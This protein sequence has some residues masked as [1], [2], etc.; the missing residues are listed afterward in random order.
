MASVEII[1]PNPPGYSRSRAAVHPTTENRGIA[2]GRSPM[3]SGAR[4][5]SPGPGGWYARRWWIHRQNPALFREY[6]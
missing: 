2:C 6:D 4:C 1:P 3:A 5:E